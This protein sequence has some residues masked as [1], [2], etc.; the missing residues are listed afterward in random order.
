MGVPPPPSPSFSPLLEI[1]FKCTVGPSWAKASYYVV[2]PYR[3]AVKA[4]PKES[5]KP[6]SWNLNKISKQALAHFTNDRTAYW[7]KDNLYSARTW[8]F[9]RK[10]VKT[11]LTFSSVFVSRT[12][13][14]YRHDIMRLLGYESWSSRLGA[15]QMYLTSLWQAFFNTGSSLKQS[16]NIFTFRK[17]K[18]NASFYSG[19][20]K[21]MQLY[22]IQ[23][24]NIFHHRLYHK[25]TVP[26]ISLLTR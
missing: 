15:L 6:L 7:F 20:S 10:S 13:C 14:L 4:F 18:G 17:E 19:K 2:S 5:N 12:T 24:G 21:F 26:K 3:Y 11:V 25:L 16:H 1:Y 9:E 8:Q 22:S 23:Q